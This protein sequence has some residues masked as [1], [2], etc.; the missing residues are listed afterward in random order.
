MKV[1]AQEV[2]YPGNPGNPDDEGT[3]QINVTVQGDSRFTDW[4]RIEVRDDGWTAP[5]IGDYFQANSSGAY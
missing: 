4:G 5:I 3:R 1:C 2:F